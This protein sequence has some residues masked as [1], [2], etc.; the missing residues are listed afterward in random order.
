MPEANG[1][2]LEQIKDLIP[3]NELPQNLKTRLLQR[4]QVLE[5][6]K[7][8][9]IFKQGDKDDYSYYLLD[10]EVELHANKQ[11][12]SVIQ[13]SSDRAK[14]ALSQLQP[15]QF[16]AKA[17]TPLRI[18]LIERNNLDQLMLLAQETTNTDPTLRPG[19]AWRSMKLMVLT[20]IRT[21]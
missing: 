11:V 5:V 9:F 4:A 17:R 14:Y 13:S 1:Q 2:L 19:A 20:M 16:S 6:K 8:R 21:G 12:D 10:G 18:L 7:S 3:I 15:R